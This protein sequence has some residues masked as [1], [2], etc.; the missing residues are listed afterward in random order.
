MTNRDYIDQINIF[1]NN[2]FNKEKEAQGFVNREF[3]ESQSLKLKIKSIIDLLSNSGAMPPLSEDKF[4]K[5]YETAIKES[6]HQNQAGMT[7]SV[8][9]SSQDAKKNLW[10]TK[11][12]IKELGWESDE[13]NTYRARYMYYLKKIGRS[14]DYI[15][16]TKRSSL[17]IIKK[18]GNP[19]S[20]QP[21]FTRGLVVG[22]VQSGK[23][24]NFNA[25]IN[26]AV[27]VGYDLVIVLSGIMEDLRIQTQ[28]RIEKEVEGKYINGIFIGVGDPHSFGIQG[29]HRDVNQV[30]IPTSVNTDF[31]KTMKEADFN[32]NHTNIL[33]CKKNT[34]VLKNLILW[35][36]N[37]LNENKD[38]I[39]IPFLIID[40]EADNASLNNLGHKGIEYASIINGHIRALLA[41]FNKKTYLGYTA[42]PF[43]NVLQD[44]NEKPLTKWKI[45]DAGQTKEFDQEASL[46]PHDF[47]ELL[48]PP[49]NYIGAKHFFET[50]LNEVKKIDPL[51]PSAIDD[52]LQ[53]FPHRV[54]KDDLQPTLSIDKD[55]RATKKED[56]FPP[57]GVLP[58]SLKDAIKCFIISTAIRTS[59]EK[60]M[61][62]SKMFQ[63]HNTMLIHIS[64]FTT[65]QTKTKNN[66]QTYVNELISLLNNDSPSDKNGIYANFEIIWNKYYAYIMENIG[67]YLPDDYEDDF[68]TPRTF[69]DIQPLLINAISDIEVKA[70]NSETKDSLTYPEGN[71]KKY[72]AI[73]GNRL[74]RGF[75]LE[76]LT[77]NYFI[78][79]TNYSDTLLQMG[80]WFGYRPGYI[81]CCKVFATQDGLD[82]FDQTTSTIEDLEQKFIEMNRNPANT[83][84]NFALRVLKHPGVLKLTRPSI[85]KNTREVNWSYSDH[86]I[87]TTKFHIDD[88]KIKRAWESLVSHIS[89]IKDK[90]EIKYDDKNNPD[91][92]EYQIENVNQLFDFFK[93][94]NTFYDPVDKEGTNHFSELEEYIKLCSKE[95]KLIKWSIVIKVS[96]N[97]AKIKASDSGL[98][99]DVNKAVRSGLKP[100]TRWAN[101]LLDNQI[102]A[103]GGG[104]SNILGGGKDMQVRLEK[105]EILSAAKEFKE[106]LFIDLKKKYK[107]LS[108]ADIQK[109][110]DKTGV[111][112]KAFRR[113]MTD[114]EGVL[115]IYL[116]DLESVFKY[117]GEEIPELNA[118]KATL[119]T[120]IPLIGYA[121]GIPEVDSKIGGNYLESKFHIE[122]ESEEDNEEFED[123]AEVL[124]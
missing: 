102:F 47:I 68:L 122:P 9:L 20:E 39:E 105:T 74:S 58:N 64:R 124:E 116:M 91:Y 18:F 34:S 11:E 28:I 70:I 14:N 89:K 87:Q 112:E 26:S 92:L 6:R 95:K 29:K 110:V 77:I 12:K 75:T 55:T 104:S 121:I 45:T 98:P 23:T 27:D 30:I 85:L 57:E 15:D 54:N 63:P 120:S 114:E 25:V 97:G 90:F 42:T 32:L 33:V 24:S 19:Q 82:K 115:I 38:K 5:L 35:L 76:G 94:P 48:F 8:S 101:E 107:D 86:L 96:G 7:P 56:N 79:N 69:K 52:Y 46:F 117:D 99:L 59:R 88:K 36:D 51:V 60:E 123:Y 111:P 37:Y 106:Q 62:Q 93:L 72:I 49:P 31:K 80:R 84:D 66:V 113:K 4:N 43:S 118:L 71:A 108:D 100:G 81:D 53:S 50:R 83:P 61:Y 67:R 3:F 2:N 13:I 1:I 40:D 65:W 17:E 16:E 22:S 44:R 103:A 119:D 78:R 41:L 73:G 21:Y 109:K 10:L